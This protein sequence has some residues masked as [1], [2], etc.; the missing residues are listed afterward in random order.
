MAVI[1]CVV[2]GAS[3]Q[4]D[5][6]NINLDAKKILLVEKALPNEYTREG[7][8][9]VK[10]YDDKWWSVD[11]TFSTNEEMTG[12]IRIKVYLEAYD[13]FKEV[14][15]QNG[16]VVLTGDVVFINVPKGSEHKATF[17]LHPG[18]AQRYGG[19]K[20]SADFARSGEHNVR[21]EVYEDGRLAVELDMEQD[22][23]PNWF[24]EAASVPDVL[25]SVEN[26]P[27]WPFEVRQYNQIQIK[28]GR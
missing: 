27:W 21:V 15:K 5:N 26:S 11:V 10:T 18:S 8:A 28:S 9:S 24:R 4:R 25:I 16:F 2:P 23:N 1:G 6:E 7:K 20:G 22:S 12:E 17:Y 13:Y 3:A 19:T 14:D